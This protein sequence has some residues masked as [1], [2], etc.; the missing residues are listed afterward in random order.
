MTARVAITG[1]AGGI[2]RALALAFGRAGYEVCLADVD[3]VRL[4]AVRAE[5][6]AMGVAVQARAFDI[7]DPAACAEA[8]TSFGDLDVLVNNAGISHRSLFADTSPDVL[9]RVMEVNFF[10][11]VHCTRA[12]LEGLRRRRGTVVAMSSVAGFAPLVGRTAYAASKHALHGFFD[13][14]RAELHHEGVRVLVVCPS[15]VDTDLDTRH[16]G[17]DG[18]VRGDRRATVGRSLSAVDVA[19]AVLVAVR[20]GQRRKLLSPIAHAALWMTRLTPG[21]YDRVMLRKQGAELL[22]PKGGR[23]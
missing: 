4:E 20:K 10:G 17:A 12:A 3:A 11:A 8:L 1:G 15:F 13:T 14:L 6:S 22:L 7:C 21:L 2:G 23:R 9:R 18:E 5:V 16:L 19:S